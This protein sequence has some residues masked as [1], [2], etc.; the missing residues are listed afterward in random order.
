M[1][2]IVVLMAGEGRRFKDAGYKRIKPFIKISERMM[3][4]HVLDGIGIENAKYIL[5]VRESFF[6]DYPEELKHIKSKYNVSFSPVRETT[7]GALST[8]LSVYD[9]IMP[10]EPVVFVDSDNLFDNIEF[11]NF[12]DF[13]IL[14]GSDA[15]VLTY[16]SDNEKFSYVKLDP[17][18]GFVLEIAEKRVVSN[19]AIVG[20]YMFSSSILFQKS[21]VNTIIYPPKEKEYYMSCAYNTLIGMGGY[22]RNF[23]ID[24]TKWKCLGTPEQLRELA[25]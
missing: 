21:A 16:N 6:R 19:M 11:A 10:F 14:S 12:L 23:Q 22:V 9:K 20:A 18:S 13:A 4:E 2:N 5:V 25:L 17:N 8:A 7:T 15:C 1:M 24:A 3:I